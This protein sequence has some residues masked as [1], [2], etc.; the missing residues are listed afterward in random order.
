[1]EM[2]RLRLTG[3]VMRRDEC[4]KPDMCCINIIS[5]WKIA[6]RVI[7]KNRVIGGGDLMHAMNTLQSA[8][9]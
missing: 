5:G 3:S 9:Q 1:M 4:V 8:G 6:D 2:A 7:K